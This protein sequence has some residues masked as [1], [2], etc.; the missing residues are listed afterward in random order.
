MSR[1]ITIAPSGDKFAEKAASA[2]GGCLLHVR[3]LVPCARGI[4]QLDSRF[5]TGALAGR[6][7]A[8]E[9]NASRKKT[10]WRSRNVRLRLLSRQFL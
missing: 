1:V 6:R 4:W 3:C 5:V 10:K 9:G 8:K 2:I 7:V